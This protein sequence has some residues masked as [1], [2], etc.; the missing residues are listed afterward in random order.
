MNNEWRY[1]KCKNFSFPNID[2]KLILFMSSSTGT[3]RIKS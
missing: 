1:T 3:I 2:N